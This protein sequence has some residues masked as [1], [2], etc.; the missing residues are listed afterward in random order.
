MTQFL[1]WAVRYRVLVILLTAL[2]VAIMVVPGFASPITVGLAL[3]RAASM[4]LIAVGLT[5]LLA[6]GQI[7]LSGGAVF[8]VAGIVAVVLQPVIGIWP[9]A[10]VGTLAGLMAGAINGFVVVGLGVNSLVATLATLLAFRA[11]GHWITQS[12]PVS[13]IDIMVALAISQ[14]HWGVLTLRAGLFLAL[15]LLLHVW[16][17]RTVAGRNLLALGSS[18]EAARSSGL[19]PGRMIIL[20]FIG[21]GVLAGGAGVLQSLAVNTGSPVFGSD[22]TIFALTAVVV[23]GTRLEGGRAT[24]LGTLGGVLTLATLTT[25]MEFSS[26]PAYV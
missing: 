7:D 22:M 15:I 24:A 25:G 23:G 11:I 9:A 20:A 10:A 3:D 4:G 19:R 21:A 6:A 8:A 5:V 16:L 13:G 18:P 2:S 17:T 12:Q 1:L 26:V 14:V